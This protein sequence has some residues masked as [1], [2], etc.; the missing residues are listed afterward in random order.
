MLQNH[1]KCRLLNNAL[2]VGFAFLVVVTA[3]GAQQWVHTVLPDA[4]WSGVACSADATT[5][6][7]VASSDGSTNNVGL[8]CISSDSG[9]TWKSNTVFAPAQRRAVACSSD[10]LKMV[11]VS[12]LGTPGVGPIHTSADSGATWTQVTAPITNWVC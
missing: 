9:F 5:V 1:W 3:R 10:G 2:G 6:L 4:S 12:S 11:A 7:V 8:T